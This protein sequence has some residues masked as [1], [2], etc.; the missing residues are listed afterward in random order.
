[1]LKILLTDSGEVGSFRVEKA[2]H[3]VDI[4][5]GRALPRRVRVGKI[6]RC[7]VVLLNF[8]ESG[9]FRT[10]VQRYALNCCSMESLLKGFYDQGAVAALGYC[11]IK[12]TGLSVNS[13]HNAAFPN[14]SSYSVP[15]HIAET[16]T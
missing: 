10:I 7:I 11:G 1:M 2:E 8:A 12:H 13:S 9:K 5:I 6:D 14:S 3:V 15:L 4:L 16:A